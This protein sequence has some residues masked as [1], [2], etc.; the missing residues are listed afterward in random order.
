M[1]FL[2]VSLVI[3]IH[4]DTVFEFKA[5][6]NSS[7]G[8]ALNHYVRL[9]TSKTMSLLTLSL[10]YGPTGLLIDFTLA[11]ARRFYSAMGSPLGVKGL[12]YGLI[13]SYLL[14]SFRRSSSS[15]EVHYVCHGATLA[16]LFTRRICCYNLCN[17][18]IRISEWQIPLCLSQ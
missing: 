3:S 15:Y 1:A 7:F 18:R 14:V 6:L 2:K 5:M 13:F 8:A 4:N 16:D 9:T 12:N 11:N 17:H 10:P